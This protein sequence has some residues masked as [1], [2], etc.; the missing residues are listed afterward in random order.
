MTVVMI[1]PSLNATFHSP[2]TYTSTLLLM[3]N[4]NRKVKLCTF[5]HTPSYCTRYSK[6]TR[7]M[8]KQRPSVIIFII[9]SFRSWIGRALTNDRDGTTLI[10]MARRKDHVEV[11]EYLME[12]PKVDTLLVIAA[13]NIARYVRNRADV[14][15]L[16]IPVV[17]RQ[18]LAGFVNY[19]E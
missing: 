10:E 16:Q 3:C 1:I 11:L 8:K 15:A 19:D 12:R 13:H 5:Q 14:E 18:F 6:S 7:K 4:I 2:H 17:M 9:K